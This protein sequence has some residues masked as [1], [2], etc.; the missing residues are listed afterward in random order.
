MRIILFF[1]IFLLSGCAIKNVDS[2]DLMSNLSQSATSYTTSS[3]ILASSEDSS[4]KDEYLKKYFAMW[5][6]DFIP[7]SSKDMFWGLNAKNGF[8]E[9]KKSIDREFFKDIIDNMQV[10]S[11]PSMRQKA[12]MVQDSDVRVLPTI[13][14]R[15]SKL[16]GYPFDRWQNSAIY[17]F[18]P[19]LILHQS[20]DKEWVLIQSSF[21]SGWVK[22]SHVARLSNKD[23]KKMLRVKSYL[24][25]TRDK[26][27]LYYR[28]TFLT[29]ARVGMI[30]EKQNNSIIGYKRDLLGNAIRVGVKYHGDDFASFPLQISNINIAQVADSIAKENYGWGGMYENRDCSAFIRDIFANFAIYL[31]RNSLAQVNYGK[32][33]GYS[34]YMK[35]PESSDEKIKFINKFAIP[36]RT[37]IHLKGHIML[38]IGSQNG[39]PLVMHQVWGISDKSG[40]EILSRV[41]ITTLTPTPSRIDYEID[42]PQSLLDRIDAINVIF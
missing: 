29:K 2:I 33:A 7:S 4:L 27:V 37:I 10:E 24:I 12:V 42:E 14:P 22:S 39:I 28:N 26:I 23:A 19:V 11:Y 30:Y 40:G 34:K 16:D 13:K 25:P 18:S 20:K 15:F 32:I 6:E 8:D 35:L 1:I 17:A 36:F 41:S 5:E 21:V 3:D 9:S 38:Y 31:P